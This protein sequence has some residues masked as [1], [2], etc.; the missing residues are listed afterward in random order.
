[1]L[2]RRGTHD[3]NIWAE[4][5]RH[6]DRQSNEVWDQIDALQ[7]RIYA[8]KHLAKAKARAWKA[9]TRTTPIPRPR[10]LKPT[11]ARR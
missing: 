8:E 2:E 5:Y 11:A 3:A 4:L 6:L 9:T 1:M 10:R 7:G